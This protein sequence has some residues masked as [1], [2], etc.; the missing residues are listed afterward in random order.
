MQMEPSSRD[1]GPWAAED[2]GLFQLNQLWDVPNEGRDLG[3]A[4]YT[5]ISVSLPVDSVLSG[6]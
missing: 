1:L 6:L 4:R 2:R 5:N 3:S